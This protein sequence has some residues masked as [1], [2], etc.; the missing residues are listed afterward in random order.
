[1]Q[2]RAAF[3]IWAY[4]QGTFK[5]TNVNRNYYAV[6][7]SLLMAVVVSACTPAALPIA[8]PTLHPTATNAPT[9]EIKPTSTATPATPTATAAPTI[10][11]TALPATASPDY[12]P[13][14]DDRSDAA[15]VIESLFN[16]VN[17]HQ[18]ARAYAYWD[19]TP[20]RPDFQRFT[21]GYQD[22]ASVSAT[23]GTI[24]GDAGAGQLYSLVPVTLIARTTAGDT[25]TFIGCYMLHLSQPAVQ[26]TLPFQPW[27]IQSAQVTQ[28]DNTANTVELLSQ[29]CEANGQPVLPQ[30]TAMPN[31][32]SAVRYLDNRTDPVELLQSLFNAINRQEYVRA[33]SYWQNN[34]QNLPSL[35]QF[36]QG[37]STT[38]AVT[39]TFGTVTPDA[40]AG[41]I[42]YMV[43]TTLVAQQTDGTRQTFVGC[44]RLHISNPD[45]QTD[46]PFKPLAIESADVKQVSNDADTG[47]LMNQMCGMP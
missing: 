35:D 19:D 37:Y 36:T 38:Q 15:A 27:G 13:Y 39:L 33:Y 12:V 44:Y 21:A 47:A 8:T 24:T 14:L 34:A 41:Q 7:A 31:D 2:R 18:Y 32:I 45:I 28:V 23:L 26:G 25:Q 46:P 43:P 20:K 10:G 17:L 4:F 42:R 11:P 29:V 16:A 40:G 1:L 3:K 30:P 5:E 9:V 22:T 6:G